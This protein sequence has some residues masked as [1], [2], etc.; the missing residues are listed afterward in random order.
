MLFFHNIHAGKKQIKLEN[1]DFHSLIRVRRKKIDN[2]IIF[3]NIQNNV[4][5]N[6]DSNI[7]NNI[8][9]Y[10]YKIINISKKSADLELI[11]EKKYENFTG[12]FHLY[13][14][15]C[16]LKTITSSLPILNQM[17]VEKITFVRCERSQGNVKITDKVLEKFKTI[18][19]SSCEQ[20][21]RNTLMQIDIINFEE[22]IQNISEEKFEKNYE[23]YICDFS[24]EYFSDKEILNF[25]NNNNNRN[26][27]LYNFLI[28]PEGGFSPNEKEK[29]NE[30]SQKK[31]VKIRKFNTSL[32]L[33]SES[34]CFTVASFFII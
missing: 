34:A 19:L 10:T 18:L 26:N 25:K 16:E 1:T 31:L 21:G 14:G 30:L 11:S 9:Y 33:K 12:K 2:N 27:N 20:C 8:Y 29:I 7:N 6:I 22:Y 17:G 32:V 3:V 23:N 5:N 28:G 24:P 4:P 15:I 13:W